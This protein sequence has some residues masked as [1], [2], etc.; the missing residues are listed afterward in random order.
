[1]ISTAEAKYLLSMWAT[2]ELTEIRRDVYYPATSPMFRD[3]QAGYRKSADITDREQKAQHVGAVLKM[4]KPVN[5]ITLRR[6]YLD[7]ERVGKATL[8]IA[9]DDFRRSWSAAFP[10]DADTSQP[11]GTGSSSR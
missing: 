7:G 11:V 8:G 3:Y 6:V 4:I 5:Q 2:Q 1:M 9:L 10:S